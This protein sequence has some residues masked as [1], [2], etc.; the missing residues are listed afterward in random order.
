MFIYMY[1]MLQHICQ[2]LTS[3]QQIGGKSMLA[4]PLVN[5]E[6]LIHLSQHTKA[7][8]YKV[9]CKD[10]ELGVVCMSPN[11][12][13]EDGPQ[14]VRMDQRRVLAISQNIRGGSFSTNPP[15][16]WNPWTDSVPHPWEVLGLWA[17]SVLV[18]PR[19]TLHQSCSHLRRP[20][21]K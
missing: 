3:S 14:S 9:K 21:G 11:S 7:H 8:S 16:T 18:S 13:L 20:S 2:L 1:L 4:S 19:W 5:R 17:A 10:L 6:F 12:Q 15:C